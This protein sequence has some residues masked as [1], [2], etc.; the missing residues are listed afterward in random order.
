MG[1]SLT[2]YIECNSDEFGKVKPLQLESDSDEEGDD[3]QNISDKA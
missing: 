1:D 3:N 2:F